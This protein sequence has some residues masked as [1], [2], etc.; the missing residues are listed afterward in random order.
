MQ[1][2]PI[3]IQEI[4]VG[5]LANEITDLLTKQ[6]EPFPDTEEEENPNLTATILAQTAIMAFLV[7]SSFQNLSTEERAEVLRLKGE[8]A[9]LKIDEPE[10]PAEG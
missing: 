4:N 5:K 3:K 7:E 9:S 1:P 6:L 8:V 2:M 10:A